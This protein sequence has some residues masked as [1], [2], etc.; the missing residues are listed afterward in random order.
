VT[1]RFF[2]YNFGLGGNWL[3]LGSSTLSFAPSET[4]KVLPTGHAWSVPTGGSGHSCLAVEIEAPGDPPTPPSFGAFAAPDIRG[5]NNK[6]QRNLQVVLVSTAPP[7]LGTPAG[8]RSMSFFA[9]VHNAFFFFRS[10]VV[11]F[12]VAPGVLR[13]LGRAQVGVVGERQAVALASKGQLKVRTLGPGEDRWIRLT[14]EVPRDNIQTQMPVVF[15]DTPREKLASGFSIVFR[16]VA[17]KSVVASNLDSH[18]AVFRRIHD[19][20]ALEG[21]LLQAQAAEQASRTPTN[22]VYRQFL[23]TYLGRAEVLVRRVIQ[24]NQGADPFETLAALGHAQEA[25]KSR[26]NMA[27]AAAHATFANA[28]DAFLTML[29][30]QRGNVADIGQ[31]LRWQQELFTRSPELSGV[32]QASG[33]A[34][35]SADF[36]L[37]F[38]RGQVGPTDYRRFMEGILP[39]LREAAEKLARPDLALEEDLAAIDSS[40]ASPVDLQRTHRGLL[41]KLVRLGESRAE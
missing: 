18:R 15:F 37:A 23:G 14:V 16:P 3:S 29:Q 40:L 22:S 10:A 4:R 41:L 33:L 28:L 25:L 36:A 39:D 27:V 20:F 35:R 19:L 1:A 2:F 24:I 11:G 26:D 38:E 8:N 34:A 13:R 6:A 32:P 30:L 31:N 7:P 5:D 17:F 12:E 9:T 21:A